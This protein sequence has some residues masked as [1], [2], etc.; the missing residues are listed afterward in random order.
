MK[1]EHSII[2]GGL[3]FLDRLSESERVKS[4]IPGR[5]NKARTHG[6]R[7]KDG[8]KYQYETPDGCKLLLR[9][10]NAIQEVFVVSDHPETIKNLLASWE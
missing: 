9:Q 2:A 5:I 10:G 4:I 3:T 8:F 1:H 6:N 7:L